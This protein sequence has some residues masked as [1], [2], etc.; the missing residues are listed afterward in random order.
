VEGF[1][2]IVKI[3]GGR[4]LGRIKRTLVKGEPIVV[5]EKKASFE[6]REGKFE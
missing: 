4:G 5:A 6:E 2:G 3:L 1:E